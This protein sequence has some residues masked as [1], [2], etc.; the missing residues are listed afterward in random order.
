MASGDE[1]VAPGSGRPAVSGLGRRAGAR[2][3]HRRAALKIGADLN[4]AGEPCV[5]L[6]VGRFER[7][8]QQAARSI[9]GRA[10]ERLALIQQ[11][12]IRG[13][14]PALGDRASSTPCILEA[15]ELEW[16]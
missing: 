6:V 4:C 2:Q 12:A 11:T 1:G 15:L 7:D 10:E 16:R 5:E 3:L 8:D 13:P 14:Q 9:A